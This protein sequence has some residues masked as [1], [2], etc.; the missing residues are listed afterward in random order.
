[1]S[2]GGWN[3]K[4]CAA[5]TAEIASAYA[6]RSAGG[7][8]HHTLRKTGEGINDERGRQTSLPRRRQR[9]GDQMRRERVN[10]LR[11]ESQ[12]Y[13]WW[14]GRELEIRIVEEGAGGGGYLEG[15]KEQ[16]G[17]LKRITRLP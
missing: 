2:N 13:R 11:A 14:V 7:R 12:S 9:L 1:V 16:G 17:E 6:V 8:S 10:A 15:Q 3:L 4:S 5:V